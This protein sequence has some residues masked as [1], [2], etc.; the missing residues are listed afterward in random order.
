MS[1]QNSEQVRRIAAAFQ[2]ANEDRA[3]LRQ[4][5]EAT[6]RTVTMLRQEVTQMQ[7]QIQQLLA[8]R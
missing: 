3:K 5:L 8:R 7:N 6:E 2:S 1:S 4:R